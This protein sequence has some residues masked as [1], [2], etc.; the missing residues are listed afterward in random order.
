[1]PKSL[2][3]F[4]EP[5]DAQEAVVPPRPGNRRYVPGRH[6]QRHAAL[7]RGSYLPL[8]RVLTVE[9]GAVPSL[10]SP[11]LSQ[12]SKLALVSAA[13]ALSCAWTIVLKLKHDLPCFRALSS[14]GNS[15][16]KSGHP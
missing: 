7:A 14:S 1:M 11:A 8:R 3:R 9:G 5:A 15:S 16:S 12:R 6:L 2:G 13:I 4:V 10:T